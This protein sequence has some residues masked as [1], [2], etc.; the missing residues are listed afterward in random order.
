M[1]RIDSIENV[2][3]PFCDSHQR[4]KPSFPW[5]SET[6]WKPSDCA[7]TGKRHPTCVSVQSLNKRKAQ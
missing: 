1:H 6:D 3:L 4:E 7:C 2:M 5:P